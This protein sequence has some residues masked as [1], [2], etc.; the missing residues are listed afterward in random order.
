MHYAIVQH[1]ITVVYR[2]KLSGKRLLGFM[3][4]I[5]VVTKYRDSALVRRYKRCVHRKA[6]AHITSGITDL[7]ATASRGSTI[8]V[9]GKGTHEQSNYPDFAF[10]LIVCAVL[11]VHVRVPF[12]ICD[13]KDLASCV[14]GMYA[15]SNC[16]R[17]CNVCCCD[18]SSQ[19]IVEIGERRSLKRMTKVHW[20][21]II[22]KL[23]PSIAPGRQSVNQ[24]FKEVVYSSGA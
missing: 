23:M 2:Q 6:L 3:P 17:P 5:N 11:F 4:T 7:A 1:T 22:T 16:R 12:I 10:P 9:N 18:F 15:S 8:I 24:E 13:E 21:M 20:T 19:S 14:T